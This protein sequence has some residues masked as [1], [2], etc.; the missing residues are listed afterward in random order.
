MEKNILRFGTGGVPLSAKSRDSID[1]LKRLK[2]LGLDHME[3]EFVH[4]VRMSEEKAELIGQTAKELGI[5]LTVHGPYYINL[6]SP[7]PEKRRASITRIVDSCRIGALAGVKSVC[8]HAAFNLNQQP[9]QVFENVLVEMMEIEAILEKEKIDNLFL[10]PETTGKPT[11]FGDID[12]LLL[13]AKELKQTR[14]CVDFAHYFAR[15]AGVYNSYEEF[16]ELIKKIRHE[17]GEEALSDL[18]IHYSGIAYGAK[19]EKN[20]LGLLDSE[21]NW[22]KMLKALKHMNVGGYMVCESPNLEED[23]LLAKEYYD[24]I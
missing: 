6:N 10:A 4:G 3:L 24:S 9:E 17:L 2:E 8:F 20:H 15:N 1:G 18:H 11:Q 5:S 22:K 16:L 23:A 7:E 13:L 21:F 14:V 12:E 19:G